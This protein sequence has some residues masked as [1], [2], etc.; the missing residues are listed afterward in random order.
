VAE[1]RGCAGSQFEPRL[2]EALVALLEADALPLLA[3]RES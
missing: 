3:L 1:L 2:V